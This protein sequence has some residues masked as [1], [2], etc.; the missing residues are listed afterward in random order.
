[1]QNV[2]DGLNLA[3]DEGIREAVAV[4]R[5]LNLET[6]SSCE[7]HLDQGS[8]SPYIDAQAPGEPRHRFQGEPEQLQVLAIKY[9]ITPS[10]ITAWPYE[11]NR[12]QRAQNAYSEW[13]QWC[14]NPSRAETPQYEAWDRENT[15][16]RAVIAKLIDEFYTTRKRPKYGYVSHENDRLRTE[17]ALYDKYFQA[18]IRQQ[19]DPLSGADREQLRRRLPLAQAEM[20]AFIAFL[21]RN[22]IENDGQNGVQ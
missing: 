8:P 7:G 5:A 14:E 11:V 10:E 6:T 17:T 2:T 3:I 15:R 1:V 21:K 12:V 22:F 9:D 19:K 20:H 18:A 13:M 4:L 16:I